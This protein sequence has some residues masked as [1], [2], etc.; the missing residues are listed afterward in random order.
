MAMMDGHHRR[1]RGAQP[2]RIF[3]D[4][5][6][7][8]LVRPRFHEFFFLPSFIE[9]G[10]IYRLRPSCPRL[11]HGFTEFYRVFLRRVSLVEKK[12]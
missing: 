10:Q 6:F 8:C 4:S 5:F 3:P 1:Q 9:F 12:Q 7:L 11:N 2:A